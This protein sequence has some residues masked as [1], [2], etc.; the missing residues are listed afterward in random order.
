ML[1]VTGD[2]S[3]EAGDWQQRGGEFADAFGR[4]YTSSRSPFV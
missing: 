4:S 2:V 1:K 3:Q